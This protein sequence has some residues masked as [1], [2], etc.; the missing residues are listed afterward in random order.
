VTTLCRASAKE[1]YHA[2]D[3][4]TMKLSDDAL[5]TIAGVTDKLLNASLQHHYQLGVP[6]ASLTDVIALVKRLANPLRHQ[7]RQFVRVQ[8]LQIANFIVRS[9]IPSLA[10]VNPTLIHANFTEKEP[11]ERLG[12]W[13]K[14]GQAQAQAIVY[15]MPLRASLASPSSRQMMRSI[16]ASYRSRRC[17]QS[18]VWHFLMRA[19]IDPQAVSIC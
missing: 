5:S 7:G 1:L 4:T 18:L 13:L 14:N 6:I 17:C 10:A 19:S 8:L 12:A 16:H 11:P 3:I 2:L 9:V 15:T